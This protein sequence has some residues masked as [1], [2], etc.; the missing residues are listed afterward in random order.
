MTGA[1][2][3]LGSHHSLWLLGGP[4]VPKIHWFSSKVQELCGL[5]EVEPL[6]ALGGGFAS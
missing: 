3:F 4:L 5:E 6:D 1:R 2:N